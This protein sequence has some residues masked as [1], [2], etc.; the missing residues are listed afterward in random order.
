[1]QNSCNLAFAHIG[2]KLGGE[3]FYEYVE[4]FGILEKTGIDLAGE[5]GGVFFSKELIVD[6]DKWG[7]A[8][9]T[10][11]SFGQTFK[12]TPLQLV[13]AVAAV[14]NGGRVL[15]PYIVAEIIDQEGNTLLKQEPTVLRNA[16]SEETSRI[17]CGMIESVVTEGTAKNAAVRGYRVGG[18]TGTSE[19]IDVF[20]EN[21]QRVRDKIVSFVGLAPMDDPRYIILVALDT[22]DASTGIY[23]SGGVMAA[24]TVG[25]VLADILP[26]LEVER[27]EP[28]SIATV[29]DV[30]GLAAQ[31]AEKSLKD[32]GLNSLFQGDG[33][34][35]TA[36]LPGADTALEQGSG[37]LLYLGEPVPECVNVPDFTG[38]TAFDAELAAQNAGVILQKNGNP[39]ENARVQHQDLPPGTA[40][41][42]GSTV[43]ITFT[44]PSA[45]D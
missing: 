40:A 17:M 5:S 10:S 36:Q 25:A 34:T 43:T 16:I 23:I 30:T 11:G 2:L 20:D 44:D 6:T 4:K 33:T 29:P 7:T 26:Y 39:D 45:H 9:L 14:V 37:V 31:A 12:I 41:E 21:G 27:A 32:L 38:M 18:K 13:R 35:V 15:E 1:M 22:P 3:R 24:P 42:P 28:P 19:K 8:S